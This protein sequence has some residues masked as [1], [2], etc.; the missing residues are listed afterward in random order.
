MIPCQQTNYQSGRSGTIQYLVVHYTANNGDTAK[1]NC[2]Y[3]QKNPGLYVS[4]HYFVDENGWEQSV[5][6]ADTAWHC[7]AITYR[8]PK[9]RNSNSIGIE[10]CS[11][12]DEKGTYY[13]LKK[14]VENAMELSTKLMQQY[15]IPKENVLR[16]YDVTG[17]VCPAPFVKNPADWTNFLNGLAVKKPA[18]NLEETMT[19]PQFDTMMAAWLEKQAQKEPDT[20]S[21]SDRQWAEQAGIIQGDTNGRKRYRSFVTR[22]ELAATLHRLAK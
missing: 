17:K 8:H 6:D 22:E 21:Q 16:H 7:G 10:L 19:Q 13:F 2:N 4:A 5:A 1:G 11:R 3:F 20:W 14:T 18:E 15:K 12:Q 9:C